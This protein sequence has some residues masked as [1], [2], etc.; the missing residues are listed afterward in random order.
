MKAHE[1][2]L[3]IARLVLHAPDAAGGGLDAGALAEVIRAEL[4][5]P[6]TA[7]RD[8]RRMARADRADR[9]VAG[10]AGLGCRIADAVAQRLESVD[11]LELGDRSGAAP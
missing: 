1:L 2:H 10:P 9:R 11:G 5:D 6:A 8:V 7:A 3:R 4:L